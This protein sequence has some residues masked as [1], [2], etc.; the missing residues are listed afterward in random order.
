MSEEFAN[1]I[2]NYSN[3]QTKSSSP[4]VILGTASGLAQALQNRPK[5]RI[6]MWPLLSVEEPLLAMG[7]YTILS[8]IIDTYPQVITYRVIANVNEQD[9]RDYTWSMSNSQFEI[10]DWEFEG[11]DDN[12]GLWG[13]AKIESNK[14][15]LIIEIEN[16]L[17]R[18]D[19]TS[20]LEFTYNSLL[21]LINDLPDLSRTIIE[22]ID[23]SVLRPHKNIAHYRE[24][25][26]SDENV[27]KLLALAFAFERDVFLALW[28]SSSEDLIANTL[29]DVLTIAYQSNDPFGFWVLSM[30][31]KRMLQ[32]GYS[33]IDD[34]DPNLI[35]NILQDDFDPI[36]PI[37]ISR[38]MFE[39]GSVDQAIQVANK[40]IMD[41]IENAD[42]YLNLA[43]L[44]MRRGRSSLAIEAFQDAIEGEYESTELYYSYAQYL[45]LI[46]AQGVVPENYVLAIDNELVEDST[47]EIIAAYERALALL[48]DQSAK[49]KE[50]RRQVLA[51]QC[52]VIASE[53]E[54]D[55]MLWRQFRQ[56]IEIDNSGD[57][58]RTVIDEMQNI[59]D[60][61][62]GIDILKAQVATDPHDIGAKINLALLNILYGETETAQNMLRQLLDQTEDESH[63]HQIEVLLL[64][65]NDPE[66]EFKI[67]QLFDKLNADNALSD[68]EIDFLEEVVER[69]PTYD[70]GHVLLARGYLSRSDDSAAV[71]VLLDAIEV[72]DDNPELFELLATSLH[73]TDTE[74][75]YQYID[76]GLKIDRNYVPL[77]ALAGLYLVE[78]GD[79]ETA[80]VFLSRAEAINPRD[81]RL[82][83]IRSEI[84]RLIN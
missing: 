78:D 47:S 6:G 23:D 14:V 37:V 30:M 35:N 71:E 48:P 75:A 63:M 20:V 70:E 27:A 25:V 46:V 32:P 80:R 76:R 40:A 50:F 29:K 36:L 44:Q 52:V 10:D 22:N 33:V 54:D 55:D 72:I 84:A 24:C 5:I 7:V 42:A 57:Y 11:L 56:L 2:I 82:T 13:R 34:F 45:N 8:W 38:Q 62:P 79:L 59:D 28:G 49:D 81:R 21:E 66:F 16:D 17:T 18:N 12:V 73:E 74:L 61:R 1:K 3:I 58:V 43:D 64:S 83:A 4:T 69:A 39:V 26:A 60:L 19:D 31:A 67:G 9:K 15:S 41:G 77:L 53:Y 51:D 68:T 65:A